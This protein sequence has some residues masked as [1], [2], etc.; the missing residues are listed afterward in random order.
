MADSA[1]YILGI[2]LILVAFAVALAPLLSFLAV[3]A[4]KVL[5]LIALVLGAI[6][7]SSVLST[8]PEQHSVPH[9]MASQPRPSPTSHD[10]LRLSIMA[11]CQ[12]DGAIC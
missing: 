4:T 7:V 5:A 2:L 6:L 12:L 8:K 3:L 10:E 9:Q 1:G 11:L